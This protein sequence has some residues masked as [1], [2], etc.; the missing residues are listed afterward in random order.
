MNKA[1]AYTN[2]VDTNRRYLDPSAIP[3]GRTSSAIF[4]I[5]AFGLWLDSYSPLW[6]QIGAGVLF[7]GMYIYLYHKMSGIAKSLMLSGLIMATVGEIFCSLIWQLYDYRLL[8]IPHY[9]PPGHIL[10]FLLGSSLALRIKKWMVW[11]VPAITAVYTIWG[12]ISGFDE[13][14][15]VL[16]GMFL[17]CLICEKDRRLYTTMFLLCLA[18]EIYGTWLGNWTWKPQV[19]VWEINTPNPPPASG[20]FYCVLDFLMLRLMLAYK[21]IV[22]TFKTVRTSASNIWNDIVE[23]GRGVSADLE[24]APERISEKE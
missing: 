4:I 9:V 14:A 7:W 21:P 17:A 23:E 16:F 5:L 11:A 1:K 13:F 6:G 20:A 8:N 22:A 24:L 2:K 10:V 15:F 3:D 18:L 19:P 12:L